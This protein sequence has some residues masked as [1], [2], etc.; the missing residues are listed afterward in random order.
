MW[1]IRDTYDPLIVRRPATWL[2]AEGWKKA[3]E[4][5]ARDVPGQR[6]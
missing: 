6:R 1:P 2:L 5:S 4:I 3:G